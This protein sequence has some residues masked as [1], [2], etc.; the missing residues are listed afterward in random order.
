MTTL[1]AL[2][3]R[4]AVVMGSDSLGTMVKSWIDPN[5]LT[6]YFDV[7]NDC[8]I[9]IGP[10]GKPVLGNLAQ[11]TCRS[12]E[13]AC[14]YI[15]SVDKLFSLAPLEMGV[16]CA[17]IAYIGERSMKSLISEFRSKDRLFR[18]RAPNYTLENVGQRLLAFL[19]SYYSRQYTGDFHPELELMLCGYDKQRYTPGIVR[20]YVHD[21][22]IKSSDYD[23]CLFLGGQTK[24]IQ[25]ILFGIDA[26]DKYRLIERANSVL[27]KYHKLLSQQLEREGINVELKK[28]ESFAPELGL[29][30]DWDFQRMQS[31]WSAFS[32]QSAI[33]C[34]S[35][36][37]NVMISSQKYAT[38]MPSVGG[39]VQIAIV[40]KDS[41][42]SYISK[43]KWRHGDNAIPVRE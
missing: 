33:E 30:R 14:N 7:T 11:I 3:T 26:Y 9:K 24:E 39:D 10:D 36:L 42:F 37:V 31:N 12:R 5:D 2:S 34:V 17:G 19:W 1:V 4:D 18:V 35:F 8:K 27:D 28:P 40:K 41:G 29:F 43:R 32:D 22:R 23:L 20:I 13:M 15:T 25:R 21:N 6:E 16:M 38:E